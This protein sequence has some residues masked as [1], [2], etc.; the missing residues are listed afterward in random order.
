MDVEWMGVTMITM[1]LVILATPRIEGSLQ[2]FH[3]AEIRAVYNDAATIFEHVVAIEAPKD[4]VVYLR[5]ATVWKLNQW[6]P[7]D[8]GLIIGNYNRPSHTIWVAVDADNRG[9]VLF[10]ELSH[11][12]FHRVGLSDRMS[13]QEEHRLIHEMEQVYNPTCEESDGS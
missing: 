1:L 11:F 2:G 3:K 10:H 9:C 8:T 5:D 12:I 7:S 13:G 4:G 6:F